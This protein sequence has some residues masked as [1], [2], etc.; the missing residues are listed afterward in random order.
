MQP[1]EET[2]KIIPLHFGSSLGCGG[3]T[4]GDATSCWKNARVASRGRQLL[5][6]FLLW[7]ITGYP[8]QVFPTATSICPKL[9]NQSRGKHIAAWKCRYFCKGLKEQLIIY[10][11][12]L[13][14]SDTP[15]VDRYF[16]RLQYVV[17][18][19]LSFW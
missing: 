8:C 5:P 1:D 2:A 19:I 6:A 18:S 10:I 7:C 9:T 17:I 14:F 3:K 13:F 4:R 12:L 15:E 11:A 16:L